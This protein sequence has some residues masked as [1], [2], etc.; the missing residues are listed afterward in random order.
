M[1][2]IIEKRFD[3]NLGLVYFVIKRYHLSSSDFEDGVQ[4]G[5]MGL[6]QAAKHYQEEKGSFSTYAIPFIIGSIKNELARLYP[7]H[8]SRKLRKIQRAM[9]AC[10]TLS[11][12]ELCQ[13]TKEKKEDVILAISLRVEHL[14]DM[15]E[16][17][18]THETECEL[19]LNKDEAILYEEHFKYGLT[20]KEMANRHQ[21]SQ[22]TIS[23]CLKKLCDKVKKESKGL[24]TPVSRN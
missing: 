14:E 8:L 22:A 13:L 12:D 7:I 24:M 15:E 10:P 6:F 4:A 18:D 17:E 3:D 1:E 9:Y 23:R 11:V 19:S 16:I 21:V 20:Q 2:Q 5:F